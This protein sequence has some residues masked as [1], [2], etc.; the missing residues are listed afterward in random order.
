MG[1]FKTNSS[2]TS[3]II[4]KYNIKNLTSLS[5]YFAIDTYELIFKNILND[6]FILKGAANLLIN[7]NYTRDYP[8]LDLDLA[9]A[10]LSLENAKNHIINGLNT[11][12]D[13][14]YMFSDFKTD[15]LII[16]NSGYNGI[17]ISYQLK[18]K[19]TTVKGFGSIDI[20]IED[21]DNSETIL[22]SNNIRYYSIERTLADKY[23]SAIHWGKDN[24]RKKD[25]I[26]IYNL[27]KIVKNKQVLFDV[28]RQL[29]KVKNIPTVKTDEWIKTWR[30]IISSLN[31][32]GLDK[33]INEININVL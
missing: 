9:I 22:T 27:Y 4:K 6:N 2:Y 23:A 1:K 25:F 11:I 26:D 20:A 28:I 21:L 10:N 8:T 31:L 18:V 33:I 15:D 3:F 12:N 17:R 14:V 13:D 32:E 7:Y 29:I 5:N 24:T 19:G 16:S 30:K